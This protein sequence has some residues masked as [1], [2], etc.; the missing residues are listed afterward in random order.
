LAA[1]ITFGQCP[2]FVM[3]GLV[4]ALHVFL[5]MSQDVDARHKATAVRFIGSILQV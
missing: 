5:A 2:L 4:P 1:S 3:A